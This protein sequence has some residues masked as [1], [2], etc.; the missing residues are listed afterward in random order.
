[1]KR[2]LTFL[3]ITLVTVFLFQSC[4]GDNVKYTVWTETETYSEF[5]SVFNTTLGEG[6]YKKLEITN[7]QW[8]QIIPNLTSEGRHR[9]RESE[10]KKWLIGYGFGEYEAT[11]ESSWLAM[12]D[13]GLLVVR[14]N[15]FVHFIL[16]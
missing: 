7:A 12:T 14:E 5:Q 13:H 11:K 8:E 4:S 6:N 10:I 16:K 2:L 9:W 15:D 1:M 3:T